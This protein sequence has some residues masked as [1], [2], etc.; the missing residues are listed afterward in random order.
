MTSN[1]RFFVDHVMP[2]KTLHA[3]IVNPLTDDFIAPVG[4]FTEKSDVPVSA[5]L[6]DGGTLRIS[7]VD[8]KQE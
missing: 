3:D 6:H 4:K 5:T 7:E 8:T 2:G 1:I